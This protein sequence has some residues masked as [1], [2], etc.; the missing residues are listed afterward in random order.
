MEKLDSRQPYSKNRGVK[1][2]NKS[3]KGSNKQ[4]HKG[5]NI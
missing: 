1:R 2:K 5:K 3:L 4:K